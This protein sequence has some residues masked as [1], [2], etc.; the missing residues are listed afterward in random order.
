MPLRRGVPPPD[1]AQVEQWLGRIETAMTAAEGTVALEAANVLRTRSSWLEIQYRILKGEEE[2]DPQTAWDHLERHVELIER[3][4]RWPPPPDIDVPRARQK[5]TI[6]GRLDDPAWEHAASFQGLYR[7]NTSDRQDE[8][9]TTWRMAWDEEYLYFAFECGDTNILCPALP[10]DDKIYSH[11]CVEMF[12]LPDLRFGSYWEIV[13]GPTGTLYD[14]LNQKKMRRWG[15]LGRPEED[16]EGLL[17]ATEVTGT[18]N[19]PGDRDTGYVVEVAVPFGALPEY[20]RAVPQAGHE[21]RLVLVRLDKHD[22]GMDPYGFIPLMSW[23][24]NIW[25]HAKVRL[26]APREP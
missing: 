9:A 1:P 7:F 23:G 19:E 11:D 21:L 18:P 4:S 12:I 22:E 3:A 14:G 8:P 6:D 10:R 17:F 5:P 24:H 26:T 20:T 15:M 2:G 16:V 13:I 25:N